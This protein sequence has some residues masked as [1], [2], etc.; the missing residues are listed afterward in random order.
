MKYK[1]KIEF[2]Y[3]GL[4]K[5]EIRDY[6]LDLVGQDIVTEIDSDYPIPIPNKG[7][8]IT[9][10]EESYSVVERSHNINKDCY[11]TTVLVRDKKVAATNATKNKRIQQLL[12]RDW[13]KSTII[14]SQ[15]LTTSSI[16]YELIKIVNQ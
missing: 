8:I 16:K 11:T 3:N 6:K 10:G 14:K 4:E 12:E 5:D 1:L 9:L 15:D 7:E 13:I 2:D